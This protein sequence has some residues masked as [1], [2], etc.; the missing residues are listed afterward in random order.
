MR[1]PSEKTFIECQKASAKTKKWD[2][3][4]EYLLDYLEKG[5]LPWQQKDWPLGKSIQTGP[6]TSYKKSFPMRDVL[7]DIAI[8]EKK[9][10]QVIFW[11]DLQK[12]KQSWVGIDDDRI[13]AAIQTY[14]PERSLT[15]WKTIAE[16]LINQT[17]PNAYEQAIGYLRKAEKIMNSQ[18]KQ[19]DWKNYINGLREKHARK[20]RFIEFKQKDI[21][22]YFS[23]MQRCKSCFLASIIVASLSCQSS[24]FFAVNELF[25]LLDENK[26]M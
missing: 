15:I 13:A 19:I 18:K 8:F 10:D 20:R 1:Y 9:P 25:K 14:A 4:R 24:V 5:T 7:I 2:K 12:K 26:T 16:R 21:K 17:N 23:A 6:D 3:V 22:Y 11:Y